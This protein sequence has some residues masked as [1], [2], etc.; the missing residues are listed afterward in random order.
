M[1][2]RPRSM[3]SPAQRCST[4]CARPGPQGRA[5]RLRARRVRRLH[6]S[7]RRR[8]GAILPDAGGAGRW[9]RLTT[10]EG[11]SPG[12]G[13]L[14]VL[15]DAFCETHGLQCGYCTPGM[16]LAVT[17]CWPARPGDAGR[18]RRGDLRQ[19][20]PLHGLRPNRRGDR[21]RRPAHARHQRPVGRT[22]AWA[23][24]GQPSMC[25]HKRRV[26]EDRRFVGG[27][28]VLRANRAA[29]DAA[30]RGFVLDLSCARIVSID[31]SAALSL[32]GVHDIV[33]GAE[34]AAAVDPL[35]VGVD[36]PT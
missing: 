29:R 26:N 15:Q 28:A 18:D 10:I 19:P 2:G 16:I 34:I 17:R 8:A 30:C 21:P 9:A 11:L 5:R 6:R 3:S 35:M 4:A 1:V 33:E 23:G 36:A 27:Q 14:S 20:L 24:A 7:G 22:C 13:E 12:P 31:A 25:R 32:P